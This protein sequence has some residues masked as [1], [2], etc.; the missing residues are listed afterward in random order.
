MLI[1]SKNKLEIDRLN[2]QFG[3]EFETK[4]LGVAKKIVGMEIRRDISNKKL[5][6]SQKGYVKRVNERFKMKCA[7]SVVTPLIAYFKLY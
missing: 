5:F 6:L 7:K 1:D 4:Y 3:K 2:T